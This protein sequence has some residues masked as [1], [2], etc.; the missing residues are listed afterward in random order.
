MNKVVLSLISVFTFI[1][2]SYAQTLTQSVRGKVYDKLTKTALPGVN[3]IVLNSEPP[4]PEPMNGH[5]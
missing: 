1:S 4:I 3:V 2:I 5:N